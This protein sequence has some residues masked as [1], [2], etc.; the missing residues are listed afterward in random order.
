MTVRLRTLCVAAVVAIVAIGQVQA[1]SL[2]GMLAISPAWEAHYNAGDLDALASIYTDDAVLMPPNM[3]SM[4]G[5]D[6]M[7]ALVQGFWDLGAVSS[8]VPAVTDYGMTGDRGWGSGPYTLTTADGT[9]LDTGK[10]L[11]LYSFGD[12]AWRI[13]RHIWNSDLPPFVPED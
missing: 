8:L 13:A 11:V 10:Y 6:A 9:V 2:D 3:P 12:G 7:R 5:T 1:Q 4:Q